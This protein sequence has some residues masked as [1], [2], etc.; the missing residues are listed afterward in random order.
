M[1][2]NTTPLAPGQRFGRLIVIQEDAKRSG[3][4]VCWLCQ[5]DCGQTKVVAGKNLR[6]G[7]VHSCGCLSRE[8][9]SIRLTQQ[10]TTHGL[11]HRVPEYVIWRGMRDRCR[12]PKNVSYKRYGGR[13]IAVCPEWDSFERFY[14]DMG[15]RPTPEHQIDRINN[16]GPYTPWNCRWAT[17]KEQASN[18]RPS[19]P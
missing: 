18:R 3:G 2:H 7:I 12:N 14:V 10:T 8:A 15:A 1:H 5:C 11:T 13:G 9:S 19:R 17:R 6:R 16:D 4:H